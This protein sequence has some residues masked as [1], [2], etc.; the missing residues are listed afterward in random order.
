VYTG[1]N[2]PGLEYITRALINSVVVSFFSTFIAIF[3]ASPAAYTFAK[4][5][6]RGRGTIFCAT[7]GFRIL[8]VTAL[9]VP[10]Y[11]MMNF[12]HLIDRLVSLVIMH[13]VMLL[14]YNIW[15]LTT[16]FQSIPSDL[17]DAAQID[18][19]NRLQSLF[20]VILPI[21][22][23]GI[24]AVVIFDF[25]VSWNEFLLAL[26]LTKSPKSYTLPVVISM[27]TNI[28][29]MMPYDYMLSAGV[30]G[31]IPPVLIALIFSRLMIKGII[32]GSIK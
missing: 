22:K 13:T 28:P 12:L 2:P 27:F 31:S 23:P 18:G 15:M 25:L 30:V 17:D 29:Q 19:C 32:S 10:I 21:V 7:I 6:F 20:K 11:L 16:F 24:A 26:I 4:M 9:M 5:R 1:N 3:L 14:P 8:P